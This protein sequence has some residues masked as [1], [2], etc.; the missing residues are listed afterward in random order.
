MAFSPDGM[1]LVSCGMQGCV[2]IDTQTQEE[3]AGPAVPG[4]ALSGGG[5]GGVA[6]SPDGSLLAIAG[7]SKS[8][9]VVLYETDAWTLKR[10]PWQNSGIAGTVAFSPDG[11]LLVAGGEALAIWSTADWELL[12]SHAISTYRR[13]GIAWIGFTPDMELL[14]VAGGIRKSIEVWRFA[15]LYSE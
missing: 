9:N 1:L 13:P 4:V 11:E 5:F 6:F 12:S 15:E 14:L 2:V 3:V 8:R 10:L 7:G